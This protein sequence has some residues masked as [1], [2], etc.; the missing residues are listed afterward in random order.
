MKAAYRR[1]VVKL[2]GEQLAGE[3]GFGI[4]PT[5]TTINASFD[6]VEWDFASPSIANGQS[7]TKLFICSPLT[8]GDVTDNLASADGQLSLE[9]NGTCALMVWMPSTTSIPAR[10]PR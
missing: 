7:S 1:L 5:S 9:A 8:P 6:V 10:R 3:N 4:S 2:S